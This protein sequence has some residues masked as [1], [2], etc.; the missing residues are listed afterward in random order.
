MHTSSLPGDHGIGYIADSS[1]AF[2]DGLKEMEIGVWQFLPTG[3]T[4]YGDSPYQPLSAFAGNAMLVGL[5]PLLL[6]AGDWGVRA[7]A[8]RVIRHWRE[9][10]AE[11]F[12]VAPDVV[13]MSALMDE[14]LADETDADL[15]VYM[16]M[17]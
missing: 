4:A 17:A 1:L 11:K 3:P 2:L 14:M 15:L 5:M 8:V 13:A 12:L 16:S 10:I 9:L 7:D 6:T